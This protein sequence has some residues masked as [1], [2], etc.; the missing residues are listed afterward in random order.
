MNNIY[1]Y[2]LRAK[3]RLLELDISSLHTTIEHC[4]P[5]MDDTTMARSCVYITYIYFLN[6]HAWYTLL[7]ASAVVVGSA[8]RSNNTNKQCYTFKS[9]EKYERV[10]ESTREYEKVREST[11]EYEKVR[12]EYREYEK[13]RAYVR[14][15]CTYMHRFMCDVYLIFVFGAFLNHHTHG[16]HFPALLA[17][18]VHETK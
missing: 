12:A 18:N 10:R 17:W 2:Y 9:T 5:N 14:D 11:R 7:L 4:W 8:G 3:L 15:E 1:S 6:G 16:E 13:V